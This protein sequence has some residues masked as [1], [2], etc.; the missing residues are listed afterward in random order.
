MTPPERVASLCHAIEYVTQ[1]GLPGDVVECGVWR[2]GS[3][4]AVALALLHLKDTT[5]SIYLFDTYEGMTAPTQ[6]DKRVGLDLSASA[7]LAG[8]PRSHAKA[9]LS[10][11]VNEDVNGEPAIITRHGSRARVQGVG[12]FGQSSKLTW[13]FAGYG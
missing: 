6:I 7:M 1:R 5:R 2:G 12:A 11:V 10:S 13:I 4:M 9:N 3:M 8:A